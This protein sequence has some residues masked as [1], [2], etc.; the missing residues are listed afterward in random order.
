MAEPSLDWLSAVHLAGAA[1]GLLLAVVLA[2]AERNR[3]A[4][5]LLSLVMLAFSVHLL[6]NLYL[7]SGYY[8]SVPHLFGVSYP[9]PFLFAPAL[10]LY[11]KAAAQRASS[12]TR[13]DLLLFVPFV[14]TIAYGLPVYLMRGEDKI[15]LY[16]ALVRGEG[17]VDLAVI[18]NLKIAYGVALTAMSLRLLYRHAER[19]KNA[20]S[21]VDRVGLR[22]LRLMVLAGTGIWALALALQLVLLSGFDRVER[23][24]DIVSVAIAVFVYGVGY[25]ALRQ[26][27]ILIWG[28]TEETE[29]TGPEGPRYERSGL[30]PEL[31]ARQRTR[32]LEAMA[33][34]KPYLN[35]DLTLPELADQLSMS[36]HNLSE[37]INTELDQNF[38][39]F[40]NGYRVDEV[41]ARLT[42]PR[43]RGVPLL[44]LALDCGFNSKSSFNAAFKKRAG[45]TPSQYRENSARA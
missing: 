29:V 11:V 5:R 13:K 40:V 17:P 22:W 31:A 9:L 32:L 1:Q 2:I 42:D 28:S 23:F 37:I 34:K 38:Y 15:A 39:D 19:V 8:R 30:S 26:P 35:S 10:F 44:S 16:E 45:M 24:D 25:I 20:Y 43:Q 14:A 7:A 18:D 33:D 36:P 6:S 12:L 27:E 41:K 21:N 4:N 3:V